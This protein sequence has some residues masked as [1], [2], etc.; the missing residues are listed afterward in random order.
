M[1]IRHIVIVVGDKMFVT[2]VYNIGNANV[3]RE[4]FI[5]LCAL[6]YFFMIFRAFYRRANFRHYKCYR[7]YDIAFEPWGRS[8]KQKFNLRNSITS[9]DVLVVFVVNNFSQF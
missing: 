1:Q 7:D 4:I 6:Q 5:I 8:D 3:L 9:L 2:Y